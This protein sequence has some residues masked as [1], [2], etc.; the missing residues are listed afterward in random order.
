MTTPNRC[1]RKRVNVVTPHLGDVLEVV[2]S[3][4]LLLRPLLQVLLRLLRLRLRLLRLLRLQL[5]FLR[6][7]LLE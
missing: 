1:R 3:S 5:L 2:V 7:P 4:A 6:L